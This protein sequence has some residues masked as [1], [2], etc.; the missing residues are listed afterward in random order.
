MVQSSTE[1]DL[2]IQ[3]IVHCMLCA[4]ALYWTSYI[5]VNHVTDL[6]SWSRV[7][8]DLCVYSNSIVSDIY[9]FEGD[10]EYMATCEWV[11]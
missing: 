11:H 7:L 9:E 6:C 4:T 2:E 1:S 8:H 5:Q 3:S 10:D